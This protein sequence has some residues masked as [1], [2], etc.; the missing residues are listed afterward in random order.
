M[1]AEKSVHFEKVVF[2]ST[3]DIKAHEGASP[4][5]RIWNMFINPMGAICKAAL[6]VV[7]L[8]FVSAAGGC[9]NSE[10]NASDSN[11]TGKS[12]SKRHVPSDTLVVKGLYMGMPG[13]DALE[14]CKEMVASSKDLVVVDFRN[15]IER[16]KD[17]T[18]KAAEKK[19]YTEKVKQAELDVDE[20]TEWGSVFGQSYD[21][22]AKECVKEE[23]NNHSLHLEIGD[24]DRA[25]ITNS[26]RIAEGMAELAGIHGYQVEWM[27]PGKRKGGTQN[28]LHEPK[29]VTVGRF[30]VPANASTIYKCCLPSTQVYRDAIKGLYDKGMQIHKDHQERVFFRLVLQDVNGNPVAK[31]KLATELAMSE[32]KYFRGLNSKQE[33]LELAE[34]EVDSFLQWVELGD[35]YGDEFV[36]VFDPSDPRTEEVKR[37]EL[38]MKMEEARKKEA[39]MEK[40][41]RNVANRE[42]STMRSQVSKMEQSD[43]DLDHEIARLKPAMQSLMHSIKMHKTLP[44]KDANWKAQL[45]EK[46]RRFNE[47][48][49]RYVAAK[50]KRGKLAVAIGEMNKK[51]RSKEAKIWEKPVVRGGKKSLIQGNA[52]VKN[53]MPDLKFLQAVIRKERGAEREFQAVMMEMAK[54]C[55]VMVEWAVLTEPA[56]QYEMITKLITIPEK[57]GDG[58][59]RKLDSTLGRGSIWTGYDSRKRLFFE[60]D[61]EDV[62]SPL[63]FRLVLK[64]TNGVEVTKEEVVK[65]WLVARGQFP[66]SD[67]LKIAKKNLI[68]ISFKKDGVREDKLK[69]LCFVWIDGKGNV[70][71]VYFNEDGM[72]KLFNAGDLSSEEFAKSL[73]NNYSGIPSLEP[74]IL[75]EDPGRGIIQS[76]T[77]IH[78]NPNGYQVK[79]FERVYYNNNGVKY[80]KTMLENDVEVAMALSL[81]GKLPTRYFTIFA[82]KPESA[83]KFD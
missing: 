74:K 8:I 79:L 14:A 2:E 36:K 17:E 7:L 55:K 52:E 20:F 81:V 61:L 45:V 12:A 54:S 78:K 10:N 41:K 68:Q 19:D 39:E 64:S 3:D 24:R 38:Q 80:N 69:G 37:K 47:M 75:R 29:F 72:A 13:D 62:K 83:R 58:F 57:N 11:T 32:C 71:E 21:P 9:G 35:R 15:G 51:I 59:V 42:I 48:N 25:T 46:K 4:F 56:S 73:V 16:E 44:K 66:P 34:K 43:R 27:L 22:S 30:E 63:W 49:E 76:T 5:L 77:W 31:N 28:G 40:E 82:I 18:T 70:K 23:K 33:K 6:I 60:K 67:K 1:T 65:N 50:E 26:L 53:G